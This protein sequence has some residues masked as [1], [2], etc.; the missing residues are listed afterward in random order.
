MGQAFF[1]YRKLVGAYWKSRF[2]HPISPVIH[3]IG[4]GLTYFSS[5]LGLWIVLDR[6]GAI[7]GWGKGQIVFIYGISLASYGIRC[8]FFI[9]FTDLPPMINQGNFDRC[10]LRPVN[11]FIQVMGSRFD[12]GSFA[13]LG[14][15]I[16]MIFL[17]RKDMGVSWNL[18]ALCWTALALCSAGL[19][20]GA[21]T[22]VIGTS[23]FFLQST[24]ALNG[25]YGNLRSFIRYPVTLYNRTVQAVLFFV[26][27]LAFASYVPAGV[28]LS[29]EEYDAAPRF[30]WRLLLLAGPAFL[31]LAYRFWLFGIRRYQSTGS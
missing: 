28:V 18:P 15:G 23:A 5:F 11:P 8:L 4:L 9:P 10:L 16:L 27:P 22:V 6:F 13:H 12:P 19:T 31:V 1:C 20:Q 25:L 29:N 2:V 30:F 3:T 26:I 14:V 7:G 24:G 17:F 21:I